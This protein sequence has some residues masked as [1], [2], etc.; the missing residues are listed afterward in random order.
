M[1]PKCPIARVSP[2]ADVTE[3]SENSEY[4]QA[5][6]S[7][8][9]GKGWCITAGTNEALVGIMG[10][11]VY[12]AV[13]Q[14]AAE[15]TPKP[16]VFNVVPPTVGSLSSGFFPSCAGREVVTCCD[17]GRIWNPTGRETV[18]D[19]PEVPGRALLGHLQDEPEV[20]GLAL[21]EHPMMYASWR[22][23]PTNG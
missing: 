20:R 7:P 18:Q 11:K 1:I 5:L 8:V 3:H 12:D 22:R 9:N 17:G 4:L 21:T 10:T 19:D 13:A 14:P 6:D 16:L 23:C 15:I 2:L